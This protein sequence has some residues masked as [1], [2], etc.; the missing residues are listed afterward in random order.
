MG[1]RVKVLLGHQAA[2]VV[3]VL[4]VEEAAQGVT[5]ISVTK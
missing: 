3:E 1:P 4:Q 5:R 2:V